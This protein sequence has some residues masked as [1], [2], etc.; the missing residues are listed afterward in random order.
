MERLK[1][2]LNTLQMRKRRLL[3]LVQ[4]HAIPQ[5]D[6]R[7]EYGSLGDQITAVEAAI[8]DS[9]VIGEHPGVDTGWGYLEHLLF[10][11][12]LAWIQSDAQEKRRIARLIFPSGIRCASEGFG[13]TPNSFTFQY[14]RG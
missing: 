5:Q 9:E 14:V 12:H 11:Q 4:D 10:N 3:T 7:D 6:F 2:Q 13:N 8:A 1:G